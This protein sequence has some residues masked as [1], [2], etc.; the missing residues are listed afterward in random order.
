MFTIV[1][2][3]S[4]KKVSDVFSVP[5]YANNKRLTAMMNIPTISPPMAR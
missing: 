4:K 1:V 3:F 2:A 5:S